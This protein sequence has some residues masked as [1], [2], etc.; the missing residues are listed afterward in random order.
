MAVTMCLKRTCNALMSGQRRNTKGG[1]NPMKAFV[2]A[3][4]ASVVL[5]IAAYAVLNGFQV[6][7][8]A[9]FSTSGVRL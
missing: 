3:V 5:G 9:A 1:A 4:V 8:D 6:P 7:A 2:S